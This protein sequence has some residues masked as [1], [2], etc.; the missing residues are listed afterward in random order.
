M[1]RFGF[2]NVKELRNEK[3]KRERERE[4]NKDIENKMRT[5]KKCRKMMKNKRGREQR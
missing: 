2:G 3:N 1:D 5:V 4:N